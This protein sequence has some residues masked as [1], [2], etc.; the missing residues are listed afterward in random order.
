MCLFA[1]TQANMLLIALAGIAGAALL[2]ATVR[3]DKSIE[4]RREH[5]IDVSGE[6]QALGLPQMADVAKAYAVGDYSEIFCS[7]KALRT[8]LHQTDGPM[9]LMD[10]VFFKQLAPRLRRDGDRE[11]IVKAI[12]ELAAADPLVKTALDKAI[13]EFRS[14]PAAPA[15]A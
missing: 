8:A 2:G 4:M 11:R 3:V 9:R 5:A 6:L 12:R 15:T 14:Q 7:L 1:V 10:E 13:E